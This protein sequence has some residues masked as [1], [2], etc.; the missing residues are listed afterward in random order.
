ME[1]VKVGE[2]VHYFGKLDVAIIKLEGELE[3]GDH[4]GFV[5]GEELL[6]EQEVAS[7]QIE[8]RNI[9]FAEAGD[10]IGLKTEQTIKG[11][12]DVYKAV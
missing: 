12:T 11:G 1:W 5:R 9:E 2:V 8:N 4:V 6:F 3:I 10:S 7:M